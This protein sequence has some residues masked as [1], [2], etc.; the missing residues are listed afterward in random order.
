MAQPSLERDRR[1][2][3]WIVV[4]LVALFA[5]VLGYSALGM[6]GMEHGGEADDPM[7]GMDHP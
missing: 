4:A 3:R 5:V 2:G 6:P 7:P 1:S